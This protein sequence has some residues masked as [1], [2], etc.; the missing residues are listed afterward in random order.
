MAIDPR[1]LVHDA[2]DERNAPEASENGSSDG[3]FSP[4]RQ[5]S[6]HEEQGDPTKVTVWKSRPRN[7]V[8]FPRDSF[9]SLD[10]LL[11]NFLL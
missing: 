2:L 5:I 11:T 10:G 8:S 7:G 9:Y 4:P 3:V 6:S 1:C